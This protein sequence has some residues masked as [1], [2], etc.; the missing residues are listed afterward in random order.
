MQPVKM[1]PFTLTPGITPFILKVRCQEAM[2]NTMN[3]N[4]SS[5]FCNADF[6]KQ[7]CKAPV[8]GSV[9]LSVIGARASQSGHSGQ[10]KLSLQLSF[11]GSCQCV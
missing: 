5:R 2:E 11:E 8:R 10:Y 6:C 3:I 9:T 4:K 7:S 1:L